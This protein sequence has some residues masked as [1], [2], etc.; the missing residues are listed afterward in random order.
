M[1][2]IIFVLAIGVILTYSYFQVKQQNP[3][4][5]EAFRESL[6]TY[7]NPDGMFPWANFKDEKSD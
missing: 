1:N 2:K 7:G 3:E 6:H 5:A 4:L